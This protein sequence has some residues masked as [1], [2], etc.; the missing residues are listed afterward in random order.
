MG[1]F[2]VLDPEK[3]DDLYH[4]VRTA[5]AN[6]ELFLEKEHVSEKPYDYL[7]DFAE[8]YIADARQILKEQCHG[9]IPF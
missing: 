9:K 8:G 2:A 7:L 6:L 4:I 1:Y 3:K 5:K